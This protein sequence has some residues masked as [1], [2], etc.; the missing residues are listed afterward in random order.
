MMI[1][2]FRD[3]FSILE[4]HQNIGVLRLQAVI[5]LT[6]FTEV[7]GVA[8]LGPF[9]ALVSNPS[10]MYEEGLFGSLYQFSGSNTEQEFLILVGVGVV[11]ILL[12]SATVATLAL[13]YIY[14]FAQRIG[15][16]IASNL[17][18]QYITSDW[19][20]HT[21]NNSSKLITNVSSECSRVTTGIIVPALVMN[22]KIVTAASIIL[23]LLWVNF[24]VAL[25]GSLI[26]G[27]VYSLIFYAV[28]SKLGANGEKLTEHQNIRI[29]TMNEG[30]GGIKD[31][32]LMNR[33]EQ[34]RMRF[35]K[36]SLIYGHAVGTQ[37]TLSEIPK[38]WVEL[39]AFGT[40]V[41]LVLFLLLI[42]D[43]NFSVIVPTLSMFAMASY[44][45]IPLFQQIYFYMSGIKFSQSALESISKDLKLRHALLADINNS[46]ALIPKSYELELDK[47]HF[48][49]PGKEQLVT[50]NISLT[51][52]ENHMVGFVGPSGSGK[53]TLIDIILGLL[54][55]KSGALRIGGTTVNEENAFI[56]Q[57]LVGY[58][59]QTLYLA[60]CSIKSNIAFG[61][62]EIDIDEDKI[63][64]ACKQ[65]QLLDFVLTLPKGLETVV[66]EK[67][68]QLSGGQKQR[69]AIARALYLDPKILVLDEATSSLDGLTEKK[70]MESI[71][72]LASDI[73]VLIIA[74]RLNT[75]KECDI[76]YYMDEGKIID[77]GGYDELMDSNPKFKN[78]SKTS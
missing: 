19:I 37:Q 56:L 49:Y 32:L 12:V 54:T 46:E 30:F 11:A 23:F 44:K 1:R 2:L 22:A 45:L 33:S 75:V 25:I 24:L 5:I 69:I 61:L 35:R 27:T 55:P 64:S 4:R 39:L 68:V 34:F 20:F 7:A 76:I 9:M 13:R 63:I 47:I 18:D 21:Q 67:G 77:K 40:M 26:F 42:S 36:S 29:R 62:E 65:A 28:K 71:Y 43:G 78:L 52:P 14:H 74:H 72:K 60:D 50:S 51:I 16:E 3:T 59:P 57:R 48:Q 58:V 66:G 8:S 70:I 31:I 15:A 53:S 38:Y 41:L 10:Q 73:T 6:A 17:F